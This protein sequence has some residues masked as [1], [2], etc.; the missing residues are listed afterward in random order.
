MLQPRDDL[1]HQ[2]L[3]MSRQAIFCRDKI[4]I[5]TAGS[6][7]VCPNF[8]MTAYNFNLALKSQHVKFNEII[9]S[10]HKFD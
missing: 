3:S 10:P 4:G 1:S 6:F 5:L 2:R 9:I 7:K 8:K